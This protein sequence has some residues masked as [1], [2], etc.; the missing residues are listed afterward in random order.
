MRPKSIQNSASRLSDSPQI[1]L[2]LS[3]RQ[4]VPLLY[5]CSERGGACSERG[6]AWYLTGSAA[7]VTYMHIVI[8]IIII[9]S[10]CQK[11]TF[12]QC[13]GGRANSC[14]CWF[15]TYFLHCTNVSGSNRSIELRCIPL[16]TVSATLWRCFMQH[17]SFQPSFQALVKGRGATN[18]YMQVLGLFCRRCMP[19]VDV[20]F[21]H[22]PCTELRASPPTTSEAGSQCLRN[23]YH[24][25]KDSGTYMYVYVCCMYTSECMAFKQSYNIFLGVVLFGLAYTKVFC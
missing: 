5:L 18:T 15:T 13:G 8:F 21:K 9:S 4:E 23:L 12:H 14:Q 6:G 7:Y 25:N 2:H 20:Q 24:K 17:S 11:Q 22:L 3:P 16:I 1:H 10:C 19:Y